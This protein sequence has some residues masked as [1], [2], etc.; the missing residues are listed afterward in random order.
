M[1]ENERE[2]EDKSVE[3]MEIVES[4]LSQ[5]QQKSAIPPPASTFKSI[6][7]TAQFTQFS[8]QEHLYEEPRNY[9]MQIDDSILECTMD[10]EG[11]RELQRWGLMEDEE[12]LRRKRDAEMAD[13]RTEWENC[14]LEKR[15]P[16]V[17]DYAS[18]I[19][20]SQ[21]PTQQFSQYATN[22]PQ[23]Y[24]MTSMEGHER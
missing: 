15:K 9:R 10:R 17:E 19:S 4:I 5:I 6:Q 8:T 21:Y 2:A 12:R 20:R 16:D 14:I 24:P 13:R 3:D 1:I 11:R 22:L 7:D 18:L 23:N